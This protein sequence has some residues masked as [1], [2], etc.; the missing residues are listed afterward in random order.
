MAD[1]EGLEQVERAAIAEAFSYRTFDQ[2]V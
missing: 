1:L 2:L